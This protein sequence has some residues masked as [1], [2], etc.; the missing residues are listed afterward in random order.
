[1][2]VSDIL[3]LLQ[4]IVQIVIKGVHTFISGYLAFFLFRALTTPL[5]LGAVVLALTYF[6]DTIKWIFLKIGG[7]LIS[8][9]LVV[10]NAIMP[11]IFETANGGY[12]SAGEIWN[13]GLN[14]L[15]NE[16]LDVLNGLGV[17]EML[18]LI[19]T[20]FIAGTLIKIYFAVMKRASLM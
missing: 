5:F 20:T 15:P 17:S 3:A 10:F 12:K 9:F 8:V 16:L 14:S 1:M 11:S 19:F 2:I 7:L 6:P 18:G 13:N 4:R